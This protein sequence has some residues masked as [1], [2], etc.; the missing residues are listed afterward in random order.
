MVPDFPVTLLRGFG[1]MTQRQG[2][3]ADYADY[4]DFFF[5]RGFAGTLRQSDATHRL[6]ARRNNGGNDGADT[7]VISGLRGLRGFLFSPRLRRNASAKRRDTSPHRPTQQR[8]QRRCR[9]KGHQQISRTSRILFPAA[10]Q[11]RFAKATRHIQRRRPSTETE[12]SNLPNLRNPTPKGNLRNPRNPL[13]TPI[14]RNPVESA[15]YEVQ[16]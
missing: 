16:S 13:I 6:I 14:P 3:S 4:A 2:L 7:R 1:R 9:H 12:M 15:K 11:E 5:P 8:W 10:L